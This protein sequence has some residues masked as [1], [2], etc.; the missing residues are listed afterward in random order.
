MGEPTLEQRPGNDPL[1]T[2]I[3]AE[4]AERED[5]DPVDLSPP[6]ST[7]IDTDALEALFFEGTDGFARLQFTYAGH[8]ITVLGDEVV[9][10][11]VGP[12]LQ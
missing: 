5:I 2:L 6:I 8:E 11:E 1:S 3:L 12:S 7:V 4:V 9:R 10:I